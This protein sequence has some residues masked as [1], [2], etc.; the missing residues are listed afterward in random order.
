[1]PLGQRL[2]IFKFLMSRMVLARLPRLS[3]SSF[4]LRS[5]GVAMGYLPGAATAARRSLRSRHAL[6]CN[7]A[8]HEREFWGN[9]LAGMVFEST[10]DRLCSM[11]RIVPEGEWGCNE[12]AIPGGVRLFARPSGSEHRW[13]GH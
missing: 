7:A 6:R 12:E 13:N 8:K 1:L 3:G 2:L 9:R 5:H 4:D 10:F 11:R